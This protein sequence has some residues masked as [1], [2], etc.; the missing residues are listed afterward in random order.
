MADHFGKVQTE[1]WAADLFL[2]NGLEAD[3]ALETGL[4]GLVVGVL[5]AWIWA[6]VDL[7]VVLFTE[8][9]L[10]LVAVGVV[11]LDKVLVSWVISLVTSCSS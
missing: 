5:D 9:F 2:D 3:V 11:G 6:E 1:I 4:L 7:E 10:D 8:F